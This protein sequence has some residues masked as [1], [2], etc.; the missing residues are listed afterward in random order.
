MSVE[1]LFKQWKN[2][3]KTTNTA[4]NEQF[5]FVS[6]ELKAGIESLKRDTQILQQSNGKSFFSKR[7]VSNT[8]EEHLFSGFFRFQNELIT[9]KKK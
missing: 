5:A 6:R 1:G 8:N 7:E 3:I 4:T 9:K 2:L